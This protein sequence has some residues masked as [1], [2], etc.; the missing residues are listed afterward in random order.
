MPELPDLQAFSINLNKKIANKIIKEIVVNSR[1]LNVPSN[2]INTKLKSQ[3]LKR[4]FREGKEL[5]LEFEKGDILGLHLMLHGEL[6]FVQES[7]TVKYSIIELV[8]SDDWKLVLS[9]FQKQ[10][11]PTLNP[12]AVD[13]PDAL[14]EKINFAYLKNLLGTKKG[15]IKNILLDQDVIRGIGNAYADE[16]LWDAKISP[17]SVSKLIPEDA[18]KQL[19]KSI[20]KVLTQAEKQI[21]KAQSDIITGEIRDFLKIHKA[22]EPESPTGGKILVKKTGSRKTYYTEEQIL[23]R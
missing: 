14:S 8:F 13:T 19:A 6:H 20:K 9:D 1:K 15:A 12:E 21:L 18:V 17:F 10:A 4:V 5:H 7:E 23:Y 16:I 22:K 3:H 2:E 11:T